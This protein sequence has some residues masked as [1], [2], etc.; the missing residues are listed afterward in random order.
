[1]LTEKQREALR[2][3]TLEDYGYS[4]WYYNRFSDSFNHAVTN[5]L[6]DGSVLR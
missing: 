2:A 5:R 1:M 6:A 3:S 4:Y